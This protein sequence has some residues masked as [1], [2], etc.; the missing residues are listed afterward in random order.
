MIEQQPDFFTQA[1]SIRI[2][3]P[4]ARFLG[5]TPTGVII[6]T[7]ADVVA[8]AGHSCPTVASAYLMARKAL[9]VLYPDTLAVRGEL[10]V[11]WRESKQTGVVGVMANVVSYLTGAADEGGFKGIAGQFQRSERLSFDADIQGELRI[12]RL[13]TQA[14]VELSCDLSHVPMHSRVRELMPLGL[15]GQATKAQ[16]LEFGEAWQ[17]RVRTLLLEHADD[18]QVIIQHL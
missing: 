13:D 7:Y 17:Q 5:A 15:S 16:L 9:S 6:Y 11:A 8:A 10:A 18:P 1:P 3:D 2:Y 12:T 4:L 14:F